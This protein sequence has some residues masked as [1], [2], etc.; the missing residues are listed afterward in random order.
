[1][2]AVLGRVANIKSFPSMG[3]AR[4]EV[5]VPIESYVD[6]VGLLFGQDALITVAGPELKDQLGRYGVHDAAEKETVREAEDG[7]LHEPEMGSAQDSSAVRD[8]H[9]AAVLQEH[10][11]GAQP[12][13]K[14]AG[15]LCKNPDFWRFLSN[16]NIDYWR[17]GRCSSEDDAARYI[18]DHCHIDSRRELDTDQEAASDF[19]TLRREW[20]AWSAR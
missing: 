12:L 10:D 9:G 13:A 1:M 3:I 17:P 20:L 8:G 14:L 5:E 15:I 2:K 16:H 7:P 18:R 6:A 11:A 19:H 4:L